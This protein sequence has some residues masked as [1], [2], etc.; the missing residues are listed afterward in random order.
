[1]SRRTLC[2]WFPD[3]PLAGETAERPVMVVAGRRVVAAT[4]AA[5]ERGVEVGMSRREAEGL[6][7]EARIRPRDPGEEARR[8]E[9]VIEL[10]EE[11]VPRVEVA[12]PGLAFV[13]VGGAARYYG[14]ERQVADVMTGKIAGFGVVHVAI[15]DGPFAA[16]WAARTA[17][18]G[19]PRVVD[20]TDR[21]LASLDVSVLLDGRPDSESLVATFH[22][23]GVTTLGRLR[24][25]PRP[26][27]ASRFGLRGLE[28]HRLSSGEDRLLNPRPIPP[29]AAVTF[30]LEDPITSLE[31]IGFLARKAASKLI[32]QLRGKGVAPHQ[33]RIEMT[34]ADGEVRS[35]VWRSLDPMTERAVV[36]RVWWQLRAWLDSND[37]GGITR[38]VL[39]PSDLSDEGRQGSL[40]DDGSG[41]FAAHRALTRAQGLVGPDHVLRAELQ[42]GRLPAEQV[43]W[44]RWGEEPPA[45]ERNPEAPW[46]GATPS[47]APALVPPEPMPLEVEW[48]GGVP[49]RI[50]LGTRWEPVAWWSG[51]WRTTGRW[52]KGEG[53][54]DRYQLVTSAGAFLCVV[55]D[56]RTY[57]AGVYD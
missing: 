21:F 20:D 42:G 10:L 19:E 14:G 11:V 38:L 30:E 41:K 7:P 35:R 25:L 51:P 28:A 4:R 36:D 5:R 48:E 40:L 27:V 3:W 45:P 16:Y 43:L 54:V 50:R 47:P 46:P 15:A 13:P 8:F 22:W 2:V 23:L 12:E 29:E 53:P 33:M 39:D 31:Q 37:R 57:L 24:D 17:P 26:A 52:W 9:E 55:S 56:G 18:P 6:C 34:T 49:S 1:M 32:E 44:C